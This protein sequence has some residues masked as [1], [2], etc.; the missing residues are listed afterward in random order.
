MRVVV[1]SHRRA[2][3]LGGLAEAIDNAEGALVAV[4]NKVMNLDLGA[5][6]IDGSSFG[7]LLAERGNLLVYGGSCPH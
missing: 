5:R 2:D 4:R 6:D 3:G 1:F 7:D